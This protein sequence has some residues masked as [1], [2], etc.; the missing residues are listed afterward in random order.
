MF[1][2]AD[3][4]F[5][6]EWEFES[7]R[8]DPWERPDPGS[9]QNSQVADVFSICK[10]TLSSFAVAQTEASHPARSLSWGVQG[11][12]GT[13]HGN[14]SQAPHNQCELVDGESS[15]WRHLSGNDGAG[16]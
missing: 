13:M 1:T 12:K 4:P 2:A 9:Q 11:E 14:D 16:M 3:A 10:L 6:D 7:D 5:T 8:L 15:P